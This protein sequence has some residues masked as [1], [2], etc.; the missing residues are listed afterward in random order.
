[1]IAVHSKVPWFGNQVLVG[2]QID[3]LGGVLQFSYSALPART[4][5]S[6]LRDSTKAVFFWVPHSWRHKRAQT[7]LQGRKRYR[8]SERPCD[9]ARG[10][11]PR[12]WSAGSHHDVCGGNP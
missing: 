4:R 1:M 10:A 11:K 3:R 6:E 12:D 2:G 9:R 7:G 5:D 8:S